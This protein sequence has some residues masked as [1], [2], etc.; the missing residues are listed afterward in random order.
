MD[1]DVMP[2]SICNQGVVGP[3][4]GTNI[5]SDLQT[6]YRSNYPRWGNQR[7]LRNIARPGDRAELV[8]EGE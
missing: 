5:I 1:I 7:W 8:Y 3:T 4:D 6:I 2:G